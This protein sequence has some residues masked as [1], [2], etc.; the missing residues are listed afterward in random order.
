MC[1]GLSIFPI[2]LVSLSVLTFIFTYVLA[3]YHDHVSAFFPYIR[4]KFVRVISEEE[5]NLKCNNNTALLF[6]A[7]SSIGLAIVANVQETAIYGLHMTGAALTLGGGILYMLIQSR[8][9]YKISPMYNTKFI[10]H[11]RVFI[12]VQC[13]IYAGL[14]ILCQIIQYQND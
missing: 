14:C 11:V 9:S 1:K 4:Y 5:G 6:G 8:L 10:C 3:V 13:I 7:L 2:A 12:A